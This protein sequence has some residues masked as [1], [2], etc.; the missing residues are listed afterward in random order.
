MKQKTIIYKYTEYN[1]MYLFVINLSL[2]FRGRSKY[3]LVNEKRFLIY[4]F[5]EIVFVPFRNDA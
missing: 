2:E 1:M 3:I 5:S 4:A